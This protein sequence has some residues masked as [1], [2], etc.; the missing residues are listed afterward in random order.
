MSKSLF[1]AA[2]ELV[3]VYDA[4]CCCNFAVEVAKAIEALRPY[5]TNEVIPSFTHTEQFPT[6]PSCTS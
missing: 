2:R 5:T 6:C 4:N 1:E 3:A